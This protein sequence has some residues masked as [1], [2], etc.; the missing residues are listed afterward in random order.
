MLGRLVLR[1]FSLTRPPYAVLGL[2][3]S[4]TLDEAKVAYKALGRA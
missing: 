1:H 4:A 2:S 3:P